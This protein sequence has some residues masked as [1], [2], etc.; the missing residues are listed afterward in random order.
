V[1]AHAILR[2]IAPRQRVRIGSFDV[3]PI[4]VTHSIADA[5][6]L[7][8]RTDAGLVVHTGDFKF[9][10]TPPDEEAFDIE[11][12]EQLG[13]EGVRLLLSDSTNIDSDGRA[14]SEQLVGQTLDAII[15]S[16]SQAVVVGLF[17]SNVH[18]LR[19]LGDIARRHRRKVLL[20]GRSMGTHA[21]VARG[22]ARS[23]GVGA[24]APYLEWRSDLVWPVD[25]ARELPR[26]EILGLATGTQGEETAALAR[27]ARGEFPAFDLAEGDTVVLS[28]RVIPGNERE[29]LRMTSEFLHRGM[30][31]RS[32]WS[33]RGAHVSG[34]AQ[35]DDQA[36]M[37]D[38]LR[39]RAFVP[40]HG[41][42]HHLVRHAELARQKG[43]AEVVVLENGECGQ[44]DADSLRKFGRV[45]TGRVHVFAGRQVPDRV[46]RDRAQLAA[47][48]VVYAIVPVDGRGRPA[49]KATLDARGVVDENDPTR[50]LDAARQEA[51]SAIL[52]V[53]E[54]TRDGLVE[55]AVLTEAVRLA[56]RASF[57][58]SLGF[59]PV[60]V[61]V[62]MRVTR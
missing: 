14:G 16:A 47:H 45:H 34:H 55:E 3:E 57:H 60:T 52:G 1:V 56:V 36:R 6:A 27:L 12:F 15:G 29:V 30:A 44:V 62:T 21:R 23:T 33:D 8:I 43:I 25:R 24:G 22:V 32:W 2:E 51:H 35:R 54:S 7:A 39:P 50:A 41:T 13:R 17:A 26:R 59:K 53:F 61:A 37:I 42:L 58:R 40:V 49:G 4:R 48:G 18:R 31:V 9:D 38:L 28:S 20:L 11:R 46:L 5:T 10:E 19:L